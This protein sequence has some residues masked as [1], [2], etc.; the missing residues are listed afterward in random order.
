MCIGQNTAYASGILF[1]ARHT[2]VWFFEL[3]DM[4]HKLILTAIVQ[5][6]PILTQLPVALA[7]SGVYAM[8]ILF[9]NPY[10]RSRDDSL[11]LLV[12]ADLMLLIL[13]GWVLQNYGDGQGLD[14]K[15]DVA[16]SVVLILITILVAVVFFHASTTA[17]WKAYRG[18]QRSQV[19]KAHQLEESSNPISRSSDGSSSG[20][21]SAPDASVQNISFPPQEEQ[22]NSNI[23]AETQ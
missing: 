6:F 1:Q 11:H 18:R 2:Q 8:L 15:S 14:T 21:A 20:Q 22:T 5:F 16:L 4:L 7:V 12:Q 13:A 19:S 9:I 17:L 3:I 10:I 23:L